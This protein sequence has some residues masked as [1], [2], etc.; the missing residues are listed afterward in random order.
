MTTTYNLLLSS[1]LYHHAAGGGCSIVCAFNSANLTDT[2]ALCFRNF[3]QHLLTH[4]SSSFS[5]DFLRKLFTHSLK[6]FSTK[7]LYILKL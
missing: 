4:L 1:T 5:K 6:H 3:S 2:R 7:L